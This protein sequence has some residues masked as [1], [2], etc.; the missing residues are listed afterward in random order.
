MGALTGLAWAGTNLRVISV[1]HGNCHFTVCGDFLL[2]FEGISVKRYSG[3]RSE[4][5]IPSTIGQLD[6]G[7][8]CRCET[9]SRV[10]FES[11]SRLWRVEGFAFQGVCHCVQSGFP[12]G[13]EK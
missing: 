4:V 9:V 10:L 11:G 6:V 8:F 5:A 3:T 1:A 12:R 2:D 7:C 13:C